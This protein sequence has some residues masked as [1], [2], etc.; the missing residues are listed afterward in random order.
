MRKCRKKGKQ[1]SKQNNNTLTPKQNQGHLVLPQ[2]PWLTF[3]AMSLE[4]F[5]IDWDPHQVEEVY[6]M[7]PTS[8][9]DL[10]LDETRRLMM[11]TP[12]YLI[13][14]QSGEYPWA[15]H[16]LLLEQYKIPQAECWWS[17]HWWGSALGWLGAAGPTSKVQC[18]GTSCICSIC[19][20]VFHF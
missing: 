10:R 20:V 12:D 11:L 4:L 19:L 16:N 6:Y 8:K 2:G 5:C 18:K 17:G 7:L 9:V 1:S 14:N 15:D 13:T 3:S